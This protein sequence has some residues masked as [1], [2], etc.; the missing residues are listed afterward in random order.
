[1]S[2]QSAQYRL[3][4]PLALGLDYNTVPDK[5]FVSCDE[6]RMWGTGDTPEEALTDF[7]ESLCGLYDAYVLVPEET[8]TA[9]AVELRRQL[10]EAIER[11]AAPDAE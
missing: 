11:E 6:F 9:D 3:R 2:N 7:W 5:W 10:K 4:R 1:M 8:L